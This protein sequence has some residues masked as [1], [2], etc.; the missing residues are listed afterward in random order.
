ML[1]PPAA[2]TS[3]RAVLTA[4]STAPTESSAA[5]TAEEPTDTGTGF[6]FSSPAYSETAHGY[7]DTYTS[8][9]ISTAVITSTAVYS[10]TQTASSTVE[11]QTGASGAGNLAAA[12][13]LALIPA[14]LMLWL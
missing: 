4:S 11:V 9:H 10:T 1:T 3:L 7:T 8:Q 12:I 6:D 14:V 5:Y 2:A 13:A